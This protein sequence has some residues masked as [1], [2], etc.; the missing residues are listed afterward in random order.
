MT[1]AI[2]TFPSFALLSMTALG[3]ALATVAMKNYAIQPGGLAVAAIAG[4]LVIAVL[5]EIILLRQGNMSLVYL[6]I[7]VAETTLVLCYASFIGNG[8]SLPQ[9]G[10]AVL[11]LAG[12]GLLSFTH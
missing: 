10:G 11:I 8:L 2:G 1:Y 6:G 9:L 4:G 5:A 7:I 3:Y 12:V